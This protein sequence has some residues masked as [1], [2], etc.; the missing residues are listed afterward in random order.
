MPITW[1]NIQGPNF[2]DAARFQELGAQSLNKGLDQFNRVIGNE[3]QRRDQNFNVG[4]D[5]NTEAALAEITS[6]QDTGAVDQALASGQYTPQALRERFGAQ[7]DVDVLGKAIAAQTGKLRAQE[8]AEFNYGQTQLAQ[9]DTV[10]TRSE[11]PEVNAISASIAAGNYDE[12]RKLLDASSIRDKASF[13]S[14]IKTGTRNAVEM[15]R[16]DLVY[17]RDQEN[18]R[19][20][21][22]ADT[23]ARDLIGSWDTQAKQENEKLKLTVDNLEGVDLAPSGQLVFSNQ[24]ES[25][26]AFTE[27]VKN[28]PDKNL[29]IEAHKSKIADFNGR[30]EGI[31]GAIGKVSGLNE[32][33]TLD[34]LTRQYTSML[35]KEGLDLEEQSAALKTFASTMNQNAEGFLSRK[36]QAKLA[37]LNAQV[38]K[39]VEFNRGKLTRDKDAEL[40]KYPVVGA[41]NVE[42]L[43]NAQASFLENVLS[44]NPDWEWAGAAG[45]ELRDEIATIAQKGIDGNPPPSMDILRLAMASQIKDERWFRD[46][47]IPDIDDFK[48]LVKELQSNPTNQNNLNRRKEIEDSYANAIYDLD[49]SSLKDMARNINRVNSEAGILDTSVTNQLIQR[50]K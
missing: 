48:A 50:S 2:S 19:Q 4:T 22:V 29:L 12:A 37:G 41:K 15:G 9:A 39:D 49:S 42:E 16:A 31:L 36:D 8:T 5:R 14:A 24:P 40:A 27:S 32:L 17:N 45:V 10:A 28:R 43:N 18:V 47:K 7:V 25:L 46:K 35:D 6:M 3:V 30:K 38:N 21:E 11:Q 34:T 33:A 23:L 26:E 20:K 13:E 44:N 1:R